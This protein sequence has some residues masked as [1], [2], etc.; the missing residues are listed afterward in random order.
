MQFTLNLMEKQN[1][2]SAI[3][4]QHGIYLP[5][6][7]LRWLTVNFLET[8]NLPTGIQAT[9]GHHLHHGEVVI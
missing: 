2:A 1:M 6:S 9:Q 8:W 7:G 5:A 3:R 4:L